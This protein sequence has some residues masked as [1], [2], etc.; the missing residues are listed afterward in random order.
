[1]S[2]SETWVRIRGVLA[3]VFGILAAVGLLFLV[4]GLVLPG[5]WEAQRSVHIDAE[6]ADVFTYV[7]SLALWDEWTVWSEV[8][9]ELSG[10]GRGTGARRSWDDPR[11]G[12]GVFE[13]TDSS[14]GTAVR[15]RVEV[16]EGA[17]TVDGVLELAP[18]DGGT[19]VHWTERGDFGRNPLLGYVAR[20][21]GRSQGAELER[22][23]ERLKAILEN[24][25]PS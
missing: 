10:P 4:I 1:M 21:M 5:R 8:E 17:L 9:S 6:P 11:Y 2:R 14:P 23:L 12:R 13:L 25:E 16:E 18:E 15:Y 20:T 3:G 19:A 24:E 7:D 22:S